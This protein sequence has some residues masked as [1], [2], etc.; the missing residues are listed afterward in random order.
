[1][2][3]NGLNAFGSGRPAASKIR[4]VV[5]RKIS[6]NRRDAAVHEQIDAGSRLLQRFETDDQM[7]QDSAGRE[8]FGSVCER[9]ELTRFVLFNILPRFIAGI[10]KIAVVIEG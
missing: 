4:T 6:H 1:M 3:I 7:R 5:G 8:D 9:F 2:S 10:E